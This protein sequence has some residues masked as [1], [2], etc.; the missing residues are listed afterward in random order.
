MG[1]LMPAA[2]ITINYVE[3]SNSAASIAATLL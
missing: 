2:K 1:K 3:N